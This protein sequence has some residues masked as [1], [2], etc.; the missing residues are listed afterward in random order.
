[1]P[2]I[3]PPPPTAQV[4]FSDASRFNPF[5]QQ[6]DFTAATVTQGE[7]PIPTGIIFIFDN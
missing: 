6:N 1:M 7:T 3:A 4:A 2:V 5:D